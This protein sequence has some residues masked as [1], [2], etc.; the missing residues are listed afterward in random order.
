MIFT[1][2]AY[3]NMINLLQQKSYPI[4][5]YKEGATMDRCAIL[6]HDVDT[7]LDKAVELAEVET[8]IGV[9]STYFILLTT[10]LYNAASLRGQQ[11]VRRILELGHEVGLHFDETLYQDLDLNNMA[12]AVKREAE[13]LSHMCKFE[14]TTVSMHRPSRKMLDCDFQ[15]PGLINAYGKTFFRDYKYVSDS[16]R[17]WRE[18]VLDVIASDAY[19]RLHILTHPFWYQTTDSDIGST[20]KQFVNNANRER[21]ES[22]KDNITCL[23][24]IMKENEVQ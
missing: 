21:Y 7:S 2:E 17:N 22:L 16:R 15:V 23:E 8:K 12:I 11:S 18:P 20:V 13:I 3:C 6:R 19:P 9:K 4:V 5:G 1:Y 10:D 14:I 24:G